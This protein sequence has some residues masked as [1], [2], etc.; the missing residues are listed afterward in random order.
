MQDGYWYEKVEFFDLSEVMGYE[1]MAVDTFTIAA[2]SPAQTVTHSL[3]MVPK[4]GILLSK[5]PTSSF[6]RYYSMMCFIVADTVRYIHGSPN[7]YM[8]GVECNGVNAINS[9][10]NN[11]IA[12]SSLTDSSLVLLNINAG[13]TYTLITMA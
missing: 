8:H 11:T 13:I 4:F 12:T 3:G 5:D 9:L 7:Y 10:N 2:N 6:T 1:H